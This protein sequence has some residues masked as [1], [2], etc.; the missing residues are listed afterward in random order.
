[1]VEYSEL[2]AN[3]TFLCGALVPLLC[4]AEREMFNVNQN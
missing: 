1:M 3:V 4:F 2:V